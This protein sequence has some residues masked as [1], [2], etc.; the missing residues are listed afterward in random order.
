MLTDNH[1]KSHS[2]GMDTGQGVFEFLVEGLE[3][4]PEEICKKCFILGYVDGILASLLM[5]ADKELRTELVKYLHE[6][7]N[8]IENNLQELPDA[9]HYH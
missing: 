9:T 6:S 2:T 7:V 4:A 8:D 1:E 5:A 3:H